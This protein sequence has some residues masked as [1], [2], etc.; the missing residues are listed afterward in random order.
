MIKGNGA[1][2]KYGAGLLILIHSISKHQILCNVYYSVIALAEMPPGPPLY[3][4]TNVNH[5]IQR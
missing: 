1:Q 4:N 2:G 3:G 5:S